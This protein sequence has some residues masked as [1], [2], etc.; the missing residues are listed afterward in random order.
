MMRTALRAGSMAAWSGFAPKPKPPRARS[1][2]PA[3]R[4]A[5]AP[6]RAG[7]VTEVA[8]F[9]SN[10]GAL[11]MLAYTPPR[12]PRPGAPL[13][14]V[15]HGCR[16]TAEAFAAAAGWIDLAAARGIPLLLPEQRTE[17]NPHRC[18]NWFKPGDTGRGRGE[19]LSIRQ[20]VR[21]ATQLYD[22]DPR[23]VFIVGL[24]AGGAMA[25]GMLA[26][27]PATFA[28]GAVVAGMP[29]GS[30]NTPH[31]ALL[32]MHRADPFG[33][34]AGLEAAVRARS[35]LRGERAWPRLSIWQGALDR[36]VDPANAELLA[37]QWSA[38]HGFGAA[39]TTDAEAA[40]GA[41]RRAWG[42]DARTAVELWTIEGM[43][44]GFPVDP[45]L[46]GGGTP[47]AWVVDA[48]VA[49]ALRIAAFWRLDDSRA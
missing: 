26:A 9:G 16:Q 33:T 23:R 35:S 15:L 48:G 25:A 2:K 27:Y 17:N 30:A 36:T 49:A 44:H 32:R 41:R 12:R 43:A 24:S 39:P 14:V 8:R 21:S 28:A 1:A 46:R 22:S 29:V 40:P 34:R 38:L 3:A 13:I 10:P 37:A 5:P 31:L 45:A 7:R 47:G 19:A 42:R 4:A 6:P 11:R 18:F 20:M